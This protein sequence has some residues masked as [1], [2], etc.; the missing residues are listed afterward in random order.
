[1][2]MMLQMEKELYDQV[3]EMSALLK[4]DG[5]QI[6]EFLVAALKPAIAALQEKSVLETDPNGGPDDGEESEG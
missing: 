4:R 2:H 6:N 5:K 1:M 3:G